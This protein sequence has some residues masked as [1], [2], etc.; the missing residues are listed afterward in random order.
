V[1]FRAVTPEAAVGAARVLAAAQ[2]RVIA[3]LGRG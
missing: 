1:L 2:A 3:G